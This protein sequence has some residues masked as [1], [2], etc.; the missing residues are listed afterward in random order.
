MKVTPSVL[1]NK[2]LINNCTADMS[3]AYFSSWNQVAFGDLEVPEKIVSRPS[4][5]RILCITRCTKSSNKG[6]AKK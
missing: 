2:L 3:P 1:P 4:N 5:P 6:Q